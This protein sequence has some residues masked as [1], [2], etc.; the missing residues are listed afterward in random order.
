M[1]WGSRSSKGAK[2]QLPTSLTPH[3]QGPHPHLIRMDPEPSSS[4]PRA[5]AHTAVRA[6]A[7]VEQQA[8]PFYEELQ[9]E[10]GSLNVSAVGALLKKL[11]LK[12]SDYTQVRAAGYPAQ[13]LSGKPIV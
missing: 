5:P 7:R 2:K 8:G 9:N 10:D 1:Q 12:D 6:R 3:S 4:S 13:Q 11:D